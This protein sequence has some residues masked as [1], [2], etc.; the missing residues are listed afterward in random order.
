MHRVVAFIQHT[1]KA[2]ENKLNTISVLLDL[3]KAFDTIDHKILLYK[4]K[5]YGI[6]GTAL[7]WFQSYLSDRHQNVYLN[8]TKS[9][10]NG[11]TFGVPQG[12]V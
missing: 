5:Y 12:S 2:Y 7:K 4:L 11:F 8:G 10:I 3:S 6:R 9:N 1:V